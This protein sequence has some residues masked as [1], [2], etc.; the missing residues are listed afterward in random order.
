MSLQARLVAFAQAVGAD[1]KALQG[2]ATDLFVKPD[3][4]SVVFVKTGHNNLAVKAGVKITVGGQTKVFATQTAITMPTLVAG[5]DYSIWVAPDG[6]V[7]AVKDTFAARATAPVSGA[8]KIGG[9]HYGLVAPGTTVASGGFSTS[10]VTGAGGSMAWAQADVDKIAGINAYSL[11]DLC[12]H[13]SGEQYGMSYDPLKNEWCGIYF[14]STA[15]HIYGASAC[16]TDVASGTV[17]PYVPPEWGGNGALKYSAL[18]VFV[19]NELLSARGLRLPYYDSAMS[20]FFGVTEGQSLSGASVTI[21]A[22]K[23]E[24]GYTSRIG[25]EQATGHQ[26]VFGGPIVSN[27]GSSISTGRGT[28]YGVATGLVLLGGSRIE[29]AGAGS[30]AAD[31]SMTLSISAWR[32]S[33]RAA[34]DHVKRGVP[35]R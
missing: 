1:V 31:F 23:R 3:Y 4:D 17:L 12:W 7:Q 11:W 29:E 19:A 28:L 15:P 13:V 22:T 10:G 8:R 24:P 34:G 35:A 32:Y 6:T 16:N 21:P 30:R 20:F 14:M 27:G 9:F 33:V 5:T 18:N 25:I 2:N 26:W